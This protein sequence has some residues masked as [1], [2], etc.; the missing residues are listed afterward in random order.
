MTAISAPSLVFGEATL[1]PFAQSDHFGL[2]Q[3]VWDDA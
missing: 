3:P 2:V 1:E